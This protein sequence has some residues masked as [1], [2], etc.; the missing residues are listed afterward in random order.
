MKIKDFVAK[1]SKMI[2]QELAKPNVIHND[3][4]NLIHLE[5]EILLAKLRKL[6]RVFKN[7]WA[8]ATKANL[9]EYFNLLREHAQNTDAGCFSNP[10]AAVN[11]IWFALAKQLSEVAKV[12]TYSALLPNVDGYVFLKNTAQTPKHYVLDDNQTRLIKVFDVLKRA[13]AWPTIEERQK[14]VDIVD[15]AYF[16]LTENEKDRVI[17]HS[18]ETEQFYTFMTKPKTDGYI[19]RAFTAAGLFSKPDEKGVLKSKQDYLKQKIDEDGYKVQCSYRE[20]GVQRLKEK[21]LARMPTVVDMFE[22][23]DFL[24][25]KDWSLLFH[26]Y[27]QKKNQV[28][29]MIKFSEPKEWDQLLLHINLEDYKRIFGFEE[30]LVDVMKNDKSFDEVDEH[31]YLYLTLSYLAAYYKKRESEPETSFGPSKQQKLDAVRALFN[32][33]VTG[34]SLEKLEESIDDSFNPLFKHRTAILD[35]GYVRHGDLYKMMLHL[36]EMGKKLRETAEL[37]QVNSMRKAV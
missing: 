36:F 6:N 28:L 31:T 23:K 17:H 35:A 9:T 1:L 16:E 3:P 13:S 14:L 30:N 15:G 24:T 12:K 27:L 10:H 5:H 18:F 37:S 21:I 33:F 20:E 32:Y 26:H 2:D 25:E 11:R 22:V 19:N 4:E 34:G 7:H 29:D 8:E